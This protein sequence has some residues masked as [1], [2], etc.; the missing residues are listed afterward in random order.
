MVNVFQILLNVVH[1]QFVH[2]NIQF[3]VHKIYVSKMFLNVHKLLLV[4][5]I[6]LIVAEQEYVE[7]NQKIVHLLSL[8][9]LIDHLNV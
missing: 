9:Q 2:H 8:A 7:L 3:Y 4:Q 5:Y 6:C 1:N